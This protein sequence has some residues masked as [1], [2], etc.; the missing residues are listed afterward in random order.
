[1]LG[2]GG[3]VAKFDRSDLKDTMN[4]YTA[5]AVYNEKI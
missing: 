2:R 1:M 3:Y 5:H 4:K